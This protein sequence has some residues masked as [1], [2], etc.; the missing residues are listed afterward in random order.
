MHFFGLCPV[1][2]IFADNYVFST[3]DAELI[4]KFEDEL[5]HEK[6]SGLSDLESSVQNVK[7]VLENGPWE[8][9]C[10][11]PSFQGSMS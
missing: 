2:Q 10:R 1:G 5:R 9:S 11:G 8:V 7:Y 6:A 4:A 3:G